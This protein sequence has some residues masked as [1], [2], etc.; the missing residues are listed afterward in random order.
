MQ[1]G[2]SYDIGRLGAEIAYKIATKKFGSK[3]LIIE[4]AAK[5]GTD[6]HDSDR[7]TLVEARLLSRVSPPSLGSELSKQ[8]E[9]MTHPLLSE[10]RDY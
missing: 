4:E 8:M 9:H 5:G 7:K 2:W 6:I 10:V 3:D 1:Y